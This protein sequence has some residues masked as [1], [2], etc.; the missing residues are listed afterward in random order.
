MF[1]L[2]WDIH[3]RLQLVRDVNNDDSPREPG[4]LLDFVARKRGVDDY[5][6]GRD[7]AMIYLLE[8]EPFPCTC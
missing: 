7:F 2:G 3:S 1:I 4:C 8:R 6:L 5:V